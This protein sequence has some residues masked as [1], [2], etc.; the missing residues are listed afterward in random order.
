MDSVV[1]SSASEKY[2]SGDLE[3]ALT[4]LSEDRSSLFVRLVE[5]SFLEE[6]GKIDTVEEKYME[7]FEFFSSQSEACPLGLLKYLEFIARTRS[8]EDSLSFF[9]DMCLAE[10]EHVTPELFPAVA[11][12]VSWQGPSTLVRTMNVFEKGIGSSK[13]KEDLVCAYSDFLA[14]HGNELKLAEFE[15]SKFLSKKSA[16]K[17]WKKWEQ[18]LI[19]F[20]VNAK[21]VRAMSKLDKQIDLFEHLDEEMDEAILLE[22]TPQ[23]ESYLLNSVGE[24]DALVAESIMGKF[25][26]QNHAPSSNIIELVL[27]L[28]KIGQLTV[29]TLD[30]RDGGIGDNNHVFRPDVTKMIRY[31]PLE[32][33]N[34]GEI[35]VSLLNLANLL[36]STPL[37]HANAQYMAD[38]CV[39]LLLSIAMPPRLI[40]DETYANVD[41]RTKQAI[42]SRTVKPAVVTIMLKK[43]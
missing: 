13:R 1:F 22:E 32:F 41:K 28:P 38:Q 43:S 18:I 20:N 9:D 3:G 26:L 11:L 34:E 8:V 31:R 37:G 42:D 33:D 30:L 27:G 2:R 19:E 23:I 12:R 39:K 6:L 35:P 29:S 17:I 5:C 16:I 24:H 7:M 25:T 15:V 14:M 21:A 40:P 36:P 10:S 4:I